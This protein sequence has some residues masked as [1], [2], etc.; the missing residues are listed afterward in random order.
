MNIVIIDE[1]F[2]II[3]QNDLST[4]WIYFRMTN[5]VG[6]G[7]Y[8]YAVDSSGFTIDTP[9]LDK[10]QIKMYEVAERW[11]LQFINHILAPTI[12]KITCPNGGIHI[13]KLAPDE[14]SFYKFV[15]VNLP[16]DD[17]IITTVTFEL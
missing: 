10:Y 14:H 8:G 6:I 9:M 4:L 15:M 3:A 5:H 1:D 17:T 13:R 2:D 12:L 11:F 16:S 7:K